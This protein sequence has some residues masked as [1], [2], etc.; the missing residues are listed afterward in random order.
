MQKHSVAAPRNNPYKKQNLPPKWRG[1]GL[2]VQPV[3]ISLERM[4]GRK[5]QL[6]CDAL[7]EAHQNGGDLRAGGRTLWVKL[8][9]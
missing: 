9:V 4:T 1:I 2:F 8:S 3:W 5:E 6:F 7:R